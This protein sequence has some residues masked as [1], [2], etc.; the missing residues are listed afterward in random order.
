MVVEEIDVELATP[1]P[2]FLVEISVR[3]QVTDHHKSHLKA[4]TYRVSSEPKQVFGSAV[5]ACS[6]LALLM[7]FSLF[8]TQNEPLWTNS[9]LHFL[10]LI[11]TPFLGQSL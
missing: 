1:D 10:F 5:P 8:F 11:S 4:F 7:S 2:F 3:G 6:K 9:Y